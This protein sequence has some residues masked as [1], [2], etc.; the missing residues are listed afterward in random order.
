MKIAIA[1][2]HAGFEMK[3]KLKAVFDE[4]E[5]LDLGT[6]SGD[7]V[8]YPSFGFAMGEVIT[9]NKAERG[10]VQGT[11]LAA[12]FAVSD[13]PEAEFEKNPC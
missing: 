6:D 5:W 3:E 12:K 13:T 1:S 11:A 4:V 9:E 2:D 10:I 8:N 7:P